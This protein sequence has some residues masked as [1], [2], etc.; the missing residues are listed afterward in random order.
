M[1]TLHWFT[2]ILFLLCTTSAMAQDAKKTTE[3]DAVYKRSYAYGAMISKGIGQ[4][5]LTED[6]KNIDQ[7]A[8]GMK[9]GMEGDKKAFE[10]AKAVV[11]TRFQSRQPSADKAAAEKLA[12]SLG[13]TMLGG[14]A[15]YVELP[16][17]DFDFKVFK[18]AFVA[19]EKGEPLKY[20]DEE[21][22]GFLK[23][24]FNP[25]NEAYKKKAEEAQKTKAAEA[26]EAGKAFLAKNGKRKEVITLESGLQ[27]EVI[28]PG[29]GAKPTINDK[30]RTHYHGTLINGDVFDSSVDR[31]E[32]IT[33]PLNGVIK[34]WQEGIPLMAVGAKY[35][36]YIPQELA[37]GM[38]SP[39]PKIP[40]GSA[41]VFEVELLEINP[42]SPEEKAAQSE[43]EKGRKFLEE[44]GKK[45]G[46]V[47]LPSGIQYLPIV[48][49]DGA[50]PT[51]DDRVTVH[52]HGTLIDGT[53]FDS[54]VDR[55]QTAT[56]PLR[57]VI[58]GWQEAIPLM[59]T[60]SKYRIF[61]P[62]NLAYGTRG[63]GKIPGG[64]VLIFD[65]ELFSIKSNK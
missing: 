41:L 30:V 50:Q 6:E 14:L 54:S 12:F 20:S 1:K 63:S 24:Y 53:V 45:P 46:V 35:K 36:F 39:S 56:F 43:I 38:Q 40:A 29:T 59:K 44:N 13:V 37:Y 62:H 47:T 15:E 33:F 28:K 4:A 32:P 5:G 18:A 17:S 42:V 23:D 58:K 64:A 49:G 21:M 2:A 48:E 11:Q 65:V 7:L 8:A 3:K 9:K 10:D 61:I 22:D 16:A 34:G 31:G 55:G 60:G 57:G 27:Y 26:I 52:Y 51:V 19:A 25:K